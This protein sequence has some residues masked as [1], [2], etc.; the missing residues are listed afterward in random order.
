MVEKLFSDPFLKIC[1][2]LWIN[3]L[4]VHFIVCQAESYWNIL[5]LRCKPLAFTSYKVFEKTKRAL[6]LVSLLHFLHEFWRKKFILL[7]SNNW[8]S[9]SVSLSL[10]LFISQVVTSQILKLTLSFESSRFFY[11]TK[12]Q[13]KNS[14][15][16]RTK[17]A[18]QMKWKSNF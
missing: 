13:N 10:Q 6:E 4:T 17:R 5:K 11:M 16:L 3:S 12:S 18:F 14:N 8:S 2:Y 15:I 9:F 7:Y 1:A